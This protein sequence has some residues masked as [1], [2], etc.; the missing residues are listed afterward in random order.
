M[1]E[2]Q[3]QPQEAAL[4]PCPFCGSR[5]RLTVIDEHLAPAQMGSLYTL[6]VEARLPVSVTVS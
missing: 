3:A 2:P 4:K 5:V 1:S 6:N